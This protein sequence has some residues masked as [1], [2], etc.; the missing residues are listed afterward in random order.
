MPG[1][2]L[3]YRLR[4]RTADDSADLVTYSTITA[5]GVYCAIKGAPTGDG[6]SLQPI[7]GETQISSYDVDVV[8]HLLVKNPVVTTLD[9][10]GYTSDA[11]FNAAWVPSGDFPSSGQHGVQSNCVSGPNTACAPGSHIGNAGSSSYAE[12]TFTGLTPG[13]TY[14]V[15]VH[16]SHS[17]SVGGIG[18]S[19]DQGIMA[20]GVPSTIRGAV[21]GCQT[22]TV[23]TTADGS[24]NI[25]VRLGYW[26]QSFL[27]DGAVAFSGLT[28]Q[29]GVAGQRIVTMQTDDASGQPQLLGLKAFL[30]FSTDRGTTWL[31][32]LA[33]YV[34]RVRLTDAET[35]RF[36]I[37]QTRRADQTIRIFEQALGTLNAGSCLLGGPIPGGWNGIQDYGPTRWKVLFVG[38]YGVVLTFVQGPFLSG[39]LPQL[40]NMQ[41]GQIGSG[42]LDFV[43]A[44]AQPYIPQHLANF[45]PVFTG[46]AGLGLSADTGLTARVTRV[47]DG[48]LAGV[49]APLGVLFQGLPFKLISGGYFVLDWTGTGLD[50][51][52]NAEPAQPTVGDLLDIYVYPTAV[53]SDAP[54]HL[55]GHPVDLAAQILT[56]AGLAYDATSATNTKA[57]VGPTLSLALRITS[58]GTVKDFLATLYGVFGFA[59]RSDPTGTLQFFSTNPS[60]A[61]VVTGTITL[62]S[63]RSDADDVWAVNDQTI[64]NRVSMVLRTFGLWS[65]DAGQ[66]TPLDL[67]LAA[68]N[69]VAVQDSDANNYGI[70]EQ[71][72]SLEGEITQPV[73]LGHGLTFGAAPTTPASFTLARSQE[74]FRRV[75]RGAKEGEIHVLRSQDPGCTIG[76]LI[77]LDLPH[78]PS[79]TV[80]GGPRQVQIIQRTENAI[81]PD[82]RFWD[83]GSTTVTSAPLPTFTLAADTND[84][85]HSADGTLTNASALTAAGAVVRVEWGTGASAPATGTLL[86]YLLAPPGNLTVAVTPPV[87]AGSTIWMRMRA[88]EPGFQPGAWTGWASVTLT[89][90]SGISGLTATPI[91]GS[92]ELLTWTNTNTDTPLAIYLS[93]SGSFPNQWITNLPAG[94]INYTLTG[95]TAG[96]TYTATLQLKESPTSTGTTLTVTFTT[97]ATTPTLSPP[98]QPSAYAGTPDPNTGLVVID[99]TYGIQVRANDADAPGVTIVVQVAVETAVGSGTPGAFSDAGSGPAVL[100][101]FTRVTLPSAPNDG[102]LRYLQA[103]ETRAGYDD[104]SESTP[105]V[106]VNPWSAVALPPTG[107]LQPVTVDDETASIPDSRQLV[108]GV[109]TTI[110]TTTPGKIAVDVTVD[111]YALQFGWGDQ[112]TAVLVN[113]E[114]SA[115]APWAGT[116]IAWTAW[117]D[118]GADVTADFDILRSVSADPPVFASLVGAGTKPFLTGQR[119]RMS[120]PTGWTRVAIA[121]GDIIAPFVNTTDGVAKSLRLQLEIQRT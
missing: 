66:S 37:G 44:R 57:A 86:V 49:F 4:I 17:T 116:L 5:D 12:R 60:S 2:T 47:S 33:G 87:A 119:R 48:T 65:G 13:A 120:A 20:N 50:Q 21:S 71:S 85:T 62:N 38:T 94:S 61:N 108:A 29:S 105:V 43:N 118:D 10:F 35:Y 92:S 40:M 80:R 7:T 1:G 70:Q 74:I 78:R 39:R 110:D 32:L 100:G 54:V 53:S 89:G 36:T 59:T 111:T 117:T 63:L 97:S 26:N 77:A 22:L 104:S 103:R 69:T 14:T 51:D 27:Y 42:Q 93:A 68:Q 90:L 30:E 81:G 6:Q 121:A 83:T 91:D 41:Y 24:G 98:T 79:G 19:A 64:V 28:I 112:S 114:A 88:E 109:G 25:T 34:N 56:L 9:D 3:D 106:S 101:G 75:L 82:F 15:A 102:K 45:A 72:W 73:A 31:V 11:A 55:E 58:G 46:G 76:D 67:V 113:A 52:G 23:V 95:L 99:G 8:D 96:A 84:P 115:I 18:G 16:M 107:T